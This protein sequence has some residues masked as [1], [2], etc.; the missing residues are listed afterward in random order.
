MGLGWGVTNAEKF[1]EHFCK[2]SEKFP[3]IIGDGRDLQN[4]IAQRGD[5]CCNDVF[6]NCTVVDQTKSTL[7][8]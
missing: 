8:R 2:V 5:V 4:D 3:G 1:P 6:T 7:K